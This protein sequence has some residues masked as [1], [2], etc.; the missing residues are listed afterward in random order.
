MA[1]TRCKECNSSISKK[2]ITC[3]H[4]NHLVP[5]SSVGVIVSG[6]SALGIIVLLGVFFVNRSEPEEKAAP[7][8]ASESLVMGRAFTAVRGLMKDPSSTEFGLSRRLVTADGKNI[9][10]GTV[11]SKNGFGGY[12]GFKRF[13]YIYESGSVMVEQSARESDFSQAWHSLC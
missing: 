2:E 9:V 11:N 4:C 3:P 8:N 10:C 13:I 1:Y 6:L 5:K 12:V 7:I